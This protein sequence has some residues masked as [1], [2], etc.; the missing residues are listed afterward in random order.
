MRQAVDAETRFTSVE[1][2]HMYIQGVKIE[3]E[4]KSVDHLRP[5]HDWPENG[6]ISF[7]QVTMHY[8]TGLPPAL[9]DITFDVN[10]REKILVVGRTGA[11]KSSIGSALF[12]L[13]EVNS[14]CIHIDGIDI[15]TISLEALRSKISIIPQ[16]PVSTKRIEEITKSDCFYEIIFL[17]R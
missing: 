17:P 9:N 1:R 12:R 15:S 6:Q 11:G 5:P 10:A 13:V 8:R 16:D 7:R 14:G 4:F 3:N 2:I